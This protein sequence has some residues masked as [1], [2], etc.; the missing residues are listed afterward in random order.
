MKCTY[1]GGTE[2][3]KGPEGGMSVNVLCANPDCRH[4]F[5]HTPALGL[6]EDLQRVEPT[7]DEKAQAAAKAKADKDAVRKAREEEGRKAFLEG[8]LISSLRTDHAYGGYAEATNNI[9]R[10]C[11]YV[12]AMVEELRN[13]D[14][15]P[16][17]AEDMARMKPTGSN[18]ALRDMEGE[19]HRD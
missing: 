11:G 17:T 4:W 3:F 5:N 18:P 19:K 8:R 10:V 13:R 12:D 15:K 6:F 1:C 16:L 2:F 9:D 14:V 7:A